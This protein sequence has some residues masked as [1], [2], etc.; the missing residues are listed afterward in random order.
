MTT[1][2]E[3]EREWLATAKGEAIA[4]A[5]NAPPLERGQYI[6]WTEQGDFGYTDHISE[7]HMAY[8]DLVTYCGQIIPP[9]HR[10][11]AVVYKTL[12]LCKHC[13]L[14]HANVYGGLGA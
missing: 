2:W 11:L 4:M 3:G 13:S 9:R 6:A 12:K 10:R 5:Q 7:K 14:K 8:S 1:A